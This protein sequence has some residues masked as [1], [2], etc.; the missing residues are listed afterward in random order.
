VENAVGFLRRNLM[1]PEPEASSVQALNETLMARCEALATTTHYRKGLPLGELFAQD[2]ASSLA[3]PG[4][5]F[6][7]VRYE[8]RKADKT[9]NVLIDGNTYAAG[10]S[11]HGRMLTV[12]LRHDVIEILDEHSEPIRSLTGSSAGRRQRSSTPHPWSRCW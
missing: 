12:G 3:L 6:D 11:F 1:V 10:P 9:G 5:G 7:P 4:V 8:S 2:M